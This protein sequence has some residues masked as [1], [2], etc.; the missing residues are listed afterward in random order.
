LPG[1]GRE[2][3]GGEEDQGD[4]APL[5]LEAMTHLMETGSIRCNRFIIC[6]GFLIEKT[7]VKR[8]CSLPM[9][10]R[11]RKSPGTSR[12]IDEGR[13]EEIGGLEDPE[14]RRILDEF[15]SELVGYMHLIEMQCKEQRNAE[16][17]V[18]LHKLDGASRTC[19][20][21]GISRAVDALKECPEPFDAK[22]NAKLQLVIKASLEEWRMMVA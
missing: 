6:L 21:G 20:F 22:L 7:S 11:K 18:T 10:D 1:S 17:R 5:P 19:G 3:R 2:H 8:K 12:L 13:I 4:S 14:I 9:L 15:T 16:L